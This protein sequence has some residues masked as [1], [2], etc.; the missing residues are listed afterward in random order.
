MKAL[1]REKRYWS[2]VSWFLALVS[3]ACFA[4]PVYVI[5]PFR[6]QGA[7]EL[8]IAL[9]VKQIG[10]AV[11]LACLILVF[12]VVIVRWRRIRG[13]IPR[14]LAV[15]TLLLAGG[16]AYLARVNIYELMFH[17]AG[18]PRFTPASQAHIDREDMVIAV[19]LNSVSRAYP[20]REMAYHHVVNDTVGGQ[21]LVAT[22]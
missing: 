6:H 12:A 10:P 7:T 8:Q 5:R 14:S 9:F 16:G 21:P 20:I 19:R 18:V 4:V 13:W 17:P 3:L 1:F 2:F 11:S 22:Y 15:F